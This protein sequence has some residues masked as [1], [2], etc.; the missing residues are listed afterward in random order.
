MFTN[1]C[2]IIFRNLRRYKSYALINIIGMA[3]GIASM[4]WGYQSYRYSFSFDNF[5]PHT[6]QVYRG[7][8]FKKGSEGLKGVFPIAAVPLA[9]QQFSAIKAATRYQGR[10]I[11]L[12]Q[13]TS[14]TFLQQVHFVD[15]G[16]FRMFDFPL[17]EGSNDLADRNTVLLTQATAKKYFGSQEPIGKTLTFYA[18]ESYARVLTVK[19]VLKDLPLNSTLQ[20]G[21]LTPFENLL[22]SNGQPI[23][24]EDWSPFAD[25][26]FFY[27]PDPAAVPE[28]VK[29]MTAWLPL[30]NKTRDDWKVSG[31]RLVNNRQTA[32]WSNIIGDN[33]LY[34]RPSDAAAYAGLVLAFLIFLSS[35]L[36]FSN[37]TIS[38]AGTR[39]KEIGMRKVMGS[40]HRQLMVQLLAECGLIALAAIL[41]SMLFNK[42]W[43][44]TFNSMFRGVLV[45]ANYLHDRNLLLFVFVMWLG[46]TLLAGTYP[47]FYLSRFNATSIFRGKVKFSGSNLFSRLMLGLQLSI[48]IITVT[49]AIAFSRNSA[50]QRDYDY[51]YNIE[52]IMGVTLPD[53]TTYVALKNQLAAVQGI[54]GLAGS[55]NILSFDYRKSVAESE[56][57]KK[58]VDF[59]EVG[60]DYPDVIRLQLAAG[61]GFEKGMEA[62]YDNALLITEKTAAL[63]GW[64]TTTALGKHV[65]I[66]SSHFTVTGVLKDL[67]AATLFE[68]TP[69]IVI[70]LGRESRFHYL[71]ISARP[72]DLAAVHEKVRAVW[73]TLNPVKPF[74][75]FYQNQIK[76]DAYE[77]TTSIATIFLWFSIV[78]ILLT[79]TGLFALVSLTTLKK[80]KE[81]ALRKVVGAR[82]E[83]ILLLISR[84]YFLIFAVSALLGSLAGLAM[85]RMLIDMIFKINSGV[86]L[87]SLL[88]AVFLL[89]LIAAVTSGIKVWEAI[90][91]NPVKLLRNE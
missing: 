9:R 7:L 50:F 54:T 46:S 16:F 49:A 71:L 39:L 6:D 83:H 52:S 63:Y 21:M 5:H 43:L 91:T 72:K 29:G 15:S 56:G 34:Q 60:R 57:I 68:P 12:R 89:F 19:G 13:D 8:T 77:T 51:G 22:N 66:D 42:W 40:T 41:L 73:K 48:A 78:S 80:M 84:N 85:T 32:S 87:D 1:Y 81:I 23:S 37:T 64:S 3:I 44:P 28:V 38:H 79:A 30:Q 31:V 86:G 53:T 17:V 55:R 75:S 33:Y 25:A 65:S 2:K 20:F 26:A 88:W 47:A 27:I 11:S 45:E 24:S 4:V 62:D 74:N 82:P 58:E 35:C 70:R 59:L 36:N 10:R 61:R 67:H 14:E 76:E 18:G 90:R 69:P